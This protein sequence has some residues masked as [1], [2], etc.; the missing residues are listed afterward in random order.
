[1]DTLPPQ[2]VEIVSAIRELYV[3]QVAEPVAGFSGE[4]HVDRAGA[5]RHLTVPR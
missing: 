1:M 4:T 2:F 5:A 3:A